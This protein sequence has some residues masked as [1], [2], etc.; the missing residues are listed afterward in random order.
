MVARAPDRS[1]EALERL[2]RGVLD[3]VRGLR[4]V[5][6]GL[7]QRLL[8]LRRADSFFRFGTTTFALYCEKVGLSA[9][10]GREMA[11]LA[12][13]SEARPEVAEKLS[14]AKVSL[15]KVAAVAE[16]LLEPSLR[17]QGEDWLKKAETTSPGDLRDLV[18][19]RKEEAGLGR[20]P[21][22][23]H[24][25]VSEEA[26]DAFR[27]CRDLAS[28]KAGT[29]LTEGQ[30]FGAVCEDFL[31]RHDPMR[32]A[33]RLETKDKAEASLKDKATGAEDGAPRT[34]TILASTV[35]ALL[36]QHGD[37]CW[38]EGCER[39]VFLDFAHRTPFRAGG[40]QTS[41]NLLRLCHEHHGQYD[42]G[43]WRLVPR[44]D[45]VTVLIDRRGV[46]VGRLCATATNP[47]ATAPP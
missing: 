8:A 1:P 38:V 10:E 36:R 6:V 29:S 15:Q 43:G 17:K 26:R 20:P 21:V 16:L 23:I 7:G 45:G 32:E 35:R 37:R 2:H 33:R 5:Q 12:E 4:S 42:G 39:R 40:G 13:S 28:R 47:P 22:S 41:S 27:R 11:A 18:R 19:E 30:A 34:R 14:E 44:R 25:S 9:Q 3:D 31:E 46:V 24:L